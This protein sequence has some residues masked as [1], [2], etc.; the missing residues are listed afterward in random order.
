MGTDFGTG[1]GSVPDCDSDLDEEVNPKALQDSDRKVAVKEGGE[2]DEVDL[3]T[4]DQATAGPSGVLNNSVPDSYKPSRRDGEAPEAQL[5]LEYCYGIRCHDVRNN[6]RYN[7]DGKLIYNCAGVGVVMDKKTN[8]QKH[9]MSHSDDIHCM[10]IGPDGIFAATGEI[11]PHPRLC[12]W[13]TKTMEEVYIATAPMTK[14][15]K[16]CSFSRDGRYLACSDMSDEHM[17][18]IFDVK[19]KLKSGEVWK[20]IAQGRGSRANIMSLGWN[21]TSDVVI[22]TC[23]K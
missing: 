10:A 15:I 17:M 18:F 3:G 21:S 23:V 14:G 7:V 20:P 8:T 5:D 22:A 19:T 13:N 9:F 2:F 12:V 4:G 1:Q 11:G 6:L 16:H